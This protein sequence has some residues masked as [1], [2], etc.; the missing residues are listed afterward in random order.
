MPIT[1]KSI[2]QIAGGISDPSYTFPLDAFAGATEGWSFR[3]LKAS[4]GGFAV[5]L[6]RTS[7][8]ALLNVGFTPNGNPDL[9]AITNFIGVGTAGVRTWYGQVNGN[10]FVQATKANQMKLRIG[11]QRLGPNRT[12]AYPVMVSDGTTVNYMVCADSSTYKTTVVDL[13]TVGKFGAGFQDGSFGSGFFSSLYIGYPRSNTG[14]AQNGGYVWAVSVGS[15][16]VTTQ[17]YDVASGF[18]SGTSNPYGLGQAYYNYATAWNW[19]TVTQNI[20]HNGGVWATSSGM[21]SQSYPN[22]TGLRIGSPINLD[23]N[24]SAFNVEWTEII[25]YGSQQSSGNKTSIAANQTA[26]YGISVP[27][28]VNAYLNG[29][30]SDGFTWAPVYDFPGWS[31]PTQAFSP[32]SSRTWHDESVGDYWSLWKSTNINNSTAMW[33]MEVRTNDIP[34]FVSVTGERSELDDAVGPWG[35]DSTIQIAYSIWVEESFASTLS[36]NTY[37]QYHYT[38]GIFPPAAFQVDRKADKWVVSWDKSGSTPYTSATIVPGRWYDFFFEIKM[39]SG[40]AGDVFNAYLDGTQVV[41]QTGTLFDGK[42][43]TSGTLNAGGYWKVGLYRGDPPIATTEAVRY[44][45]VEVVDKSVTD[46][47]ARITSP[48]AHP[49]HA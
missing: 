22:A 14:N 12:G 16:T 13:F 39:G 5:Q 11:G 40:A 34:S 35:F 15:N 1:Q 44:A 3:K 38:N 21:A 47:S 9:T 46:I 2:I 43:S 18:L 4:Y 6:Q 37:G 32:V 7:D 42:H 28:S 10:N 45:N 26:Y 29:T 27:T 19:D 24:E 8:D 36:W 31:N 23:V 30:A 48:L 33:R 25:L 49:T 20:S 17:S 41:A